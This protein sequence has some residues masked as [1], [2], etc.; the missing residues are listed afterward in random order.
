MSNDKG[1]WKR[2]LNAG[3]RS[4]D[5]FQ[6]EVAAEIK[7]L[8]GR[9][10]FEGWL[11]WRTVGAHGVVVVADSASQ[12]LRKGS[13][14]PWESCMAAPVADRDDALLVPDVRRAPALAGATFAHAPGVGA[15]AGVPLRRA[16]GQRF[17]ALCAVDGAPREAPPGS[18]LRALANAGR[19][20]ATLI[21][22][23]FEI[24]AL[25]RDAENDLLWERADA[26]GLLPA[27][28]W[29]RIAR[30]EDEVRQPL[31][32]PAA[33]LALGPVAAGRDTELMAC[34]QP[35]VGCPFA[36]AAGGMRLA[37]VPECD[38]LQAAALEQSLNRQLQSC[39]ARAAVVSAPCGQALVDAGA[40]ALARVYD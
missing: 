12:E 8:R 36:E 37:V 15:F 27:A 16:D 3:V 30:C 21:E 23:E 19:R 20:L 22:Q 1:H 11:L 29:P 24:A 38:A 5:T 33:A 25:T 4:P 35:L 18:A 40:Q 6:Y 39:G 2:L 10:S 14:V 17:G 34:V 28:L 26:R 32:S 9:L 7:R 13:M 31:A